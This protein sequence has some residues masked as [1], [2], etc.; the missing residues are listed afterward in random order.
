MCADPSHN[1]HTGPRPPDI[2]LVDD[3]PVTVAAISG[4]LSA[5]G[6]AVASAPS[7]SA[8]LRAAPG[9]RPRL[10]ILDISMP[11]IDGYS[12]CRQLRAHPATASVPILF[13]SSSSA[14]DARL[15]GLRAGGIDFL[16]KTC[17]HDELLARVDAHLQLVA[18]REE[19]T[20]RNQALAAANK[21]LEAG[22]SAASR[23]QTAM[24]PRGPIEDERL[25]FAWRWLPCQK[26]GGDMVNILRL[27]PGVF[28]VN[29]L[30]VS[31]HGLPASL[32]AVAASYFVS[33]ALA[34][35]LAPRAGPSR[36]SPARVLADFS[37]VLPSLL[38]GGMFLTALT[39]IVDS[40]RGIFT[41][42]SAGHPGPL[43][44]TRDGEPRFI[45]EGGPP[46]GLGD[47]VYRDH[48][49]TLRSGDLVL[50]YSDGVY[51]QPSPS[52]ERFG[53]E[54]LLQSALQ[55]GGPAG[56]ESVVSGLVAELDRWRGALPLE[57]DASLLAFDLGAGRESA[58]PL[59]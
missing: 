9:M 31:G 49:V 37:R 58:F 19:L 5:S 14:P 33:A 20:R 4:L 16:G 43:V 13:L 40:G 35:F 23:I 45:D 42:A 53:R 18:M 7:G 15:S 11:D 34:D 39:G 52:G 12:V 56:P 30:D 38:P 29:L 2:L 51:E 50:L 24:L 32:L 27:S 46:A 6:Y 47:G 55:C 36:P 28:A 48:A 22:L 59:P 44:T 57:D 8:A 26:L 21:A 25:R 54:R 17:P 1:G 10:L 3:D 41:F